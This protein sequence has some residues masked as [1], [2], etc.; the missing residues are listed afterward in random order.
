MWKI[1][2]PENDPPYSTMQPP[3]PSNMHFTS[4]K[5]LHICKE[6]LKRKFFCED[7][8]FGTVKKLLKKY[9]SLAVTRRFWFGPESKLEGWWNVAKF[10][11]CL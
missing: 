6:E 5:I 4:V 7:L 2:I 8:Y 1:G 9:A 3:A 11:C 10:V